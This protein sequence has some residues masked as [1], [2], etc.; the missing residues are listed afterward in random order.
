MAHDRS[1]IE[2]VIQHYFDGLYEGDADKLGAI[3]HPSADL[4]WQ[5]KGEL[6]VLTAPDWLDRVRKRPSAKS[7]GK[8]RED[9]T[10]LIDR[11]DAT[12]ALVKVRCQ[13]PPR[14]FTDYLV[15]MK[16]TDGWTIVSK[17]YRYDVKE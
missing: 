14:Y 1:T 13:L 9:F 6:Q 3:F 10:V 8:A 15:L 16:L 4:R 2:A 12:T 7:E 5:E 17:S 11:S